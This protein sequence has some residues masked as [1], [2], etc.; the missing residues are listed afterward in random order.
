[1]E[2]RGGVWFCKKGVVCFGQMGL[3]L[4]LMDGEVG[5]RGNHGVGFGFLLHGWK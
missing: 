2:R 4:V 3:S 1:M 5:L